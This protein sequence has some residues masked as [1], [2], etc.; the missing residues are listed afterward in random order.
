MKNYHKNI[1]ITPHQKAEELGFAS[2]LATLLVMSVVLVVVGGLSGLTVIEQKVTRNSVRSAQAYYAAESGIEDSVYRLIKGKNYLATN[3]LAVGEAE[4]SISISGAGSVKTIRAE[5]EQSERFRNLQV[6]LNVG[7]EAVSFYYGVQVGEGGLIMQNNSGVQGS[8]YSNGPV[9]GAN[10]AS[11]S[12]DIWVASTPSSADQQSILTNADFPFGQSAPRVDI[13][14]SFIPAISDRLIKVSLY[15]RKSGSPANKSVRILADSGGQPSKSMITPGAYGT[16]SASQVSALGYG[17]VEITMTDPPWLEAGTKYW[18]LVDSSADGGNYYI[19]G[20]DSTDS[21][22]AGSGKY[23]P[24]WNASAPVWTDINGDLNFRAM[25][26]GTANG[27]TQ[28]SVGGNA[29]AHSIS[30][31]TIAG[32]AYYQAISG[33]AVGGTSYPGSVDPANENMPISAANINDWR[34][35]AA[36]GG[37]ISGDY[38]LNAG[39]IGSLGPKKIEGN[40]TISNGGDL[41][42]IGTIYVT[43]NINIYNNA[44][45]RLGSGYTDYSGAVLTDGAISVSNNSVFYT[46]PGVFLLFLSTRAGD[47]VNIAN[48]TDTVIFYATQGSVNVSNNATLK[49]VVAYRITLNNNSRIIYDS[50][51]ASMHFSS[52]SGGIWEINSWSEVP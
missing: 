36:S 41:T 46:N 2:L 6:S 31:C 1:K 40:L 7:Q 38:I 11:I 26:G 51:L 24:N 23:S 43:G 22:A 27:L 29:H 48:N 10:G 5:G 44:K 35:E 19:S 39:A 8:I 45:V 34:A 47:A 9:Q 17:W 28:V 21:Y 18:I 30:N 37:T 3:S 32:D 4:T 14:Q 50:G 49:E 15:L 12:G 20:E 33:S 13:A 42:V 25:L 16:L 52:G